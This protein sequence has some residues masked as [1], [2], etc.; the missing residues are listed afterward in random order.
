MREIH[1]C[2]DGGISYSY[3]GFVASIQQVCVRIDAMAGGASRTAREA[4]LTPRTPRGA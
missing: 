4:L 3:E 1:E 2:A